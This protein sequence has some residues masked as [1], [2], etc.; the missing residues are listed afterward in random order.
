MSSLH[1]VP[2]VFEWLFQHSIKEKDTKSDII[3]E[4]LLYNVTRDNKS[5]IFVGAKAMLETSNGKIKW[6]QGWWITSKVIWNHPKLSACMEAGLRIMAQDE[7]WTK[8]SRC[9]FQKSY[10]SEDNKRSRKCICL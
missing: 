10:L 9:V 6:K 8:R 4:L 5:K 2:T 3:Q 1:K 7:Y